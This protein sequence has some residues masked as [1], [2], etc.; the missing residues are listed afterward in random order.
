MSEARTVGAA[1]AAILEEPAYEAHLAEVINAGAMVRRMVDMRIALGITQ[2]QVAEALQCSPSR[3]SKLESGDDDRVS[4]TDMMAYFAALRV[5]A[6]LVLDPK[7]LPTADRLRMLVG[8]IAHLL[9]VVADVVESTGNV[10]A[11]RMKSHAFLGEVLLPLLVSGGVAA[12][13]REPA[14]GG[15]NDA[16]EDTPTARAAEPRAGYRA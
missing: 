8:D 14:D 11:V 10:G 6:R 4:W 5:D 15:S 16:S 3:I 9:G 12:E 2:R 1:M 7:E 13:R